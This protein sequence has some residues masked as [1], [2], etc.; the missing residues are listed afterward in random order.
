MG[1]F[2]HPTIGDIQSYVFLEGKI[3]EIYL[4]AG[5][6]ATEKWDTADIEYE[7][8]KIFHN[9]P[10]RYHC[11]QVGVERSN[12]AVV[13][14]GRGFDVGDKVILMA[15]IGTTP[16]MGEEYQKM[17]IVAHR[18]GM[19]PCT[20]NYVLIRI[21]A[22]DF[23]P[24][25]PPYGNWLEGVY[26]P[27]NPGS[28]S[29]EYCTVWD[30][31][32]RTVATVYNPTT[33]LPYVFPVTVEELKPVLDY[34][35]FVDEELFTLTSQGDEESQEAGFTPDW[36]SDPQGNKIR[37]G[38]EPRAWWTTYDLYANPIFNLLANTSL[39]LFTDSAGA[40]N[41]SF[42]K[43]MEKF[44][45]GQD[46][47]LKWKTASPQALNDD[48]RIFD[49]K[50]SD[51]TQ[52]MPA[53]T[54]ARLQELQVLIGQMTDAINNLDS[55]KITRWEELSGMVPLIDPDLQNELVTLSGD[56]AISQYQYYKNV[57]D[58][59]QGEADNI[60]E[61]SVFIPW[62]I[63]HD[64]NGNPLEGKSYHMQTAY[65]EDEIWVC[66]K[67]TYDGT[68][69]DYCDAAWKFVRLS[70]IPPYISI[71]EPSPEISLSLEEISNLVASSTMTADDNNIFS[72]GTLK[73]INDGGFHRT[74]HP[75][76]KIK[77]VGSWRMK[78]N[79]IPSNPLDTTFITALNTRTEHI[80]VWHRYDNW[81]N[82]F[83]YSVATWGVD[84]T[85]WFKSNAEQW[86]IKANFIDTP[87][88]S[89]WHTAPD[90]EA[91]IW[92]LDGINFSNAT[93][94]ARRDMPVN[95][96]F[97]RQTKHSKRVICQ[98]YI[99]QRQSVSMFGDESELSFVKQELNKGIY[100]HL[101][102]ASI[103][104]VNGIDYD[105]M[106]PEEK[107]AVISDRVYLRSEY[108]GEVGHN[109]PAALRANRNEVEIM[110]SCDLYSTLQTNFGRKHPADQVRNGLLEYEIQKLI[111]KY[112][113]DESF[114]LK[115]FSEFK[116]EARII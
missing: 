115:D 58:P 93:I 7:S 104:Y 20:Y 50:G 71:A 42:T 105:T 63:A 81:M 35:T 46:N 18:D 55:V 6:V 21:S 32:K 11:Q 68:V 80:D 23:I 62:A 29:H 114:G 64:K 57:K 56:P 70:E 12:S 51:T 65:G 88:G 113:T 27:N 17:Y 100:D 2:S 94:T 116:M 47:I 96:Q 110:A 22:G 83:Q 106:T 44:N 16:R 54:Q 26:V 77:G 99:V 98:I 89:M 10:I 34:F 43:A 24:H 69:I 109:P 66:G 61:M 49:V 31:K 84:R 95:A 52:E 30:S 4:E 90:W 37:D 72:Y 76:L 97:I 101:D 92:Y 15:K 33:G 111:A 103:K 108:P 91:A 25:N 74:S 3:L 86:R 85:W 19:M 8:H 9:A 87:I 82:S 39:A 75:A 28:H 5:N 59:A 107:K 112:Y 53:E 13:D 73:R 48:T 60:L 102:P 78:Q 36:K 45:A 38:A 41:G 14:G 40:S 79:R 1:L 67:Q